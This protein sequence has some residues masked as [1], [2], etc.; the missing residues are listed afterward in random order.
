[1]KD[2]TLGTFLERVGERVD[3]K[4]R[5]QS[6]KCEIHC[7]VGL[8]EILQGC[9]LRTYCTTVNG[10]GGLRVS[11]N[12]ISPIFMRFLLKFSLIL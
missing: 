9:C 4:K 8:L 2:K 3:G 7:A 1:M 12:H 10:N 5:T 6:L 11:C